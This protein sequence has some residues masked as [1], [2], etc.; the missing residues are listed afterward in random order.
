MNARDLNVNINEKLRLA[1]EKARF[2]CERFE[3]NGYECYVVGGAVRDALIGKTIYDID[4]TTSALPDETA[5][6]FSD[7]KLDLRGMKYGSVAVYFGGERYEITTFRKESGYYDRRRPS[8]IEFCS[9]VKTDLTRRDFTCNALAFGFSIGLIDCFGGINDVKNKVL[10]T[11]GNPLT[12][13]EEDSLRILRA[14]RFYSVLGFT[15]DEQL[16]NAI[17]VRREDIKTLPKERVYEELKKTII[18]E[19]FCECFTCNCAAFSVILP[20][21]FA[22]VYNRSNEAEIKAYAEKICI[23]LKLLNRSSFEER[24]AAL[25]YETAKIDE[26][27]AKNALISFNAGKKTIKAV[28]NYI[29]SYLNDGAF[30]L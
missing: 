6:I 20:E 25:F 27:A 15:P 26:S 17:Y 11:V 9:D 30:T 22:P 29:K 5:R 18:G 2:F 10:R 23:P 21:L 1:L 4:L 14:L 8:E 28:E 7:C 16:K 13:L 12:R 24:F 3:K 19:S